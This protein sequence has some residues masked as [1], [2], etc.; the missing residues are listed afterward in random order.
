MSKT[1]MRVNRR[2]RSSHRSV[3]LVTVS[4]HTQHCHLPTGSIKFQMLRKLY[5]S[6]S[7]QPTDEELSQSEINVTFIPPPW[8]SSLALRFSLQMR[9]HGLER[10]ILRSSLRPVVINGIPLLL[11]A[12]QS[13][14]VCK[15]QRLIQTEKLHLTDYVVK[16]GELTPLGEVSIRDDR[17]GII[18]LLISWSRLSMG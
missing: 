6:P 4:T 11:E 3:P 1:L 7:D 13:C 17:L 14:D 9:R 15:L 10:E 2:Y 18:I 8:L 12:I 5:S 16:D